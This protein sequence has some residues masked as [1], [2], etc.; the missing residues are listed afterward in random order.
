MLK[1]IEE[2]EKDAKMSKR[3][4]TIERDVPDLKFSLADCVFNS[5]DRAKAAPVFQKFEFFSL[6]KRLSGG[7]NAPTEASKKMQKQKKVKTSLVIVDERTAPTFFT[8]VEKASTLVVREMLSGQDILTSDLL[9]FV[10]IC[11]Q[12]PYYIALQT[13]GM[14][15]KEKLFTIFT[16]KQKTLIGHDLKQLVKALLTQ[17]VETR[18]QLFDVMIASYVVNSS[19][20]AHDLKSIV[21]RELGKDLPAGSDQSSLFGVNPEVVAE[22]LQFVE[23]LHSRYLEALTGRNDLGLFEKIEMK[24]IPVLAQMELY[25]VAVDTKL[26]GTLSKEVAKDIDQITK[27]IWREAGVEFNV[28]SSVQLRDILFDTMKLPMHGIKKGKTGF[29]TAASELEKLRGLHPIIAMIEEHRELAKL[30]NTYIDALPTYINKKTGRIHTTFNQTVAATGRLSSLDPNLQNIPIRTELGKKIRDAFIADAGNVLIA[31][32]YSQIELRIVA[33]L[34]NDEK[35]IEIFN[36]GEDIH[37]ATAAAINN[38]PLEKVTKQMRYAAKEVNFGVLYGMGV[39]GLSSRTGISQAEAKDFIT[40]YF[41]E[42]A[43]VK[44]YVDQTIVFAKKEGYIETLF[45][46]RR[47]IPELKSD[48]FQLRSAGE[49]MA[50]NMP[51]QGTAADLIKLA[52]IAVHDRLQSSPARMTQSDGVFSRQQLSEVRMIL[53]VHDELVFEVKKGL[54]DKVSDLVKTAMEGVAKL[55][56]P[57]EVHVNIGK[58]WGELK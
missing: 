36:K 53:Q 2:G 1:K 23:E 10:I 3:L 25:G 58:R 30:Q 52:M 49:R 22:E 12:K 20:R 54:E 48:N 38:V 34:A 4:A 21:I 16:N 19:T 41:S 57:I 27:K 24:L 13:L 15:E 31:A 56:V 35:M 11:Q 51:I 14:K 42:F 44:K 29:S 47:Y 28:A 18:A 46:R 26:L 9:G 40:K 43:G 7:T 55:R 8:L 37:A 39:Y 6:L 45:G 50:V 5:I 33:S 17:G 32:D